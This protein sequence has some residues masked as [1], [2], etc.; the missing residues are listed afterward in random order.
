MSNN[1]PKVVTVGMSWFWPAL[2][3]LLIALKLTN[4]IEWSW[5]WVLSPAWMGMLLIFLAVCLYVVIVLYNP[6]D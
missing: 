1:E 4:Q 6:K 3:L 2:Q 5:F